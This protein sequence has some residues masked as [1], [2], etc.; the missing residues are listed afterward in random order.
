MLRFL[1]DMEREGFCM[2]NF[3]RA[4]RNGGPVREDK[5]QLSMNDRPVMSKSIAIQK[6]VPCQAGQ[7]HLGE[8]SN[9]N[10]EIASVLLQPQTWKTD[11]S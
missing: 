2:C 9:C 3:C 6:L 8:M 11:S 7:N 1:A 4:S 5:S 10:G